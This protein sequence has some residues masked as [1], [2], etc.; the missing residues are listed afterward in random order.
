M[1]VRIA[2]I[3]GIRTI[4]IRPPRTEIVSAALADGRRLAGMWWTA[5]IV[6]RSSWRGSDVGSIE[7]GCTRLHIAIASSP[8]DSATSPARTTRADA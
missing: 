2:R 1:I 7:C 4:D 5:P 3:F 8:V 6:T